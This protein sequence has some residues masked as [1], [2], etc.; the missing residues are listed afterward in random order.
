M[1]RRSWLIS[2]AV[3][4]LVIAALVGGESRGTAAGKAPRVTHLV[5]N[6]VDYDNV[7][8]DNQE[9]IEI[10]NGTGTGVPLA[11]YEVVL[12]NGSD[13]TEYAR[14]SLAR[15]GTCLASGSYLVIA[16]IAVSVD[17][18]ALVIRLPCAPDQ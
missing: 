5:I 1:R 6:E 7:G 2:A 4:A 3:G 9:F 11:D 16:D 18:P 14:T 15:A 17:P 12:V 10:F 13:N 8:T